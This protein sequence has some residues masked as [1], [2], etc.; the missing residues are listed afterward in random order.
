MKDKIDGNILKYET[1]KYI[2]DFQHSR[3]IRT[4]G[5]TI[6]NGK[7]TVSGIDKK[8][9]NLLVNNLQ[10]NS[11]AKPRPKAAKEENRNTFESIDALYERQVLTINA[12]ESK[13]LPLKPSQ[14]KWLKVL[15]PKK[16]FQILPIALAQVKA[17]NTSENLLN[18][19]LQIIYSFYQPKEMLKKCV[20]I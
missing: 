12:F 11:K 4:F 6:F 17:R 7:T 15:T 5:G 19:I 20:R 9:S 16:M 10:F 8:Q 2:C 13:V 1:N 14:E 3:K 18:E